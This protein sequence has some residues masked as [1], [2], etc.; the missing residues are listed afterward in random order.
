MMSST[1]E[2]TGPRMG[3]KLAV[4]LERHEEGFVA[5]CSDLHAVASGDTEEEALDNLKEAILCLLEELGPEVHE[6]LQRRTGVLLDV[7]YSDRSKDLRSHP[8]PSSRV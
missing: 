7:E 1:R 5:Y 8:N 3:Y 4:V 6:L 2:R